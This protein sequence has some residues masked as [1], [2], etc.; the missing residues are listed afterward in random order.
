MEDNLIKV[1]TCDLKLTLQSSL[2]S[3][4]NSQIKERCNCQLILDKM[5]KTLSKKTVI[6][7]INIILERNREER[8]GQ[9]I[10]YNPTYSYSH[11]CIYKHIWFETNIRTYLFIH[12]HKEINTQI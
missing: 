9:M 6:N 2:N 7:Y 3:F 8:E 10:R 1:L 11:F 4:S 12:H 5:L